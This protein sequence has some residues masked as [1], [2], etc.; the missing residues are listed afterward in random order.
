MIAGEWLA[1]GFFMLTGW[2]FAEARRLLWPPKRKTQVVD[3]RLDLA[4][5]LFAR[6]L[7]RLGWARD[8]INAQVSCGVDPM[9]PLG[10]LHDNLQSATQQVQIAI[11]LCACYARD[12]IARDPTK[13]GDDVERWQV[14][15]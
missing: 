10:E 4:D 11:G 13:A 7:E 15:E 6:V 3:P 14:V 9:Q 1:V 2:A 12:K 8:A 5:W